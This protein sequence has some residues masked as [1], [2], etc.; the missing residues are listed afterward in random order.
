MVLPGVRK[1]R[2]ARLYEAEDIFVGS[3]GRVERGGGR[4][5]R[6]LRNFDALFFS[7]SRY[8]PLVGPLLKYF[9]FRQSATARSREKSRR[10]MASARSL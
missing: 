4:Y 8:F 3:H 5:P 1:G 2:K 7:S 9:V 6:S 10:R